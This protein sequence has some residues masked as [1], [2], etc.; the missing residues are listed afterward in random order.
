MKKQSLRY[1]VPN[2]LKLS[3]LVICIIFI[4]V[5]SYSIYLYSTVQENKKD[6][7][8]ASIQLAQSET[9]IKNIKEVT[10]FHGDIFYHVVTGE[11]GDGEPAVAFV[12]V[13]ENVDEQ[14]DVL[15]FLLNDTITRDQVMS[16]WRQSCVSCELHGINLGLYSDEP[17]WEVKYINKA[18]RYVFQYF[19]LD[20]SE[21]FGVELR[22]SIY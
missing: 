14:S 12:P 15:F 8:S 19:P 2:W 17:V 3:I 10:R 1:T 9:E 6:G 11:S 5:I 20:G 7:F 16:E 21:T 4:A 22:R 13:E 18:D